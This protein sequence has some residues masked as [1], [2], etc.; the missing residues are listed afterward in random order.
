VTT[1]TK[2]VTSREAVVGQ[3]GF[4]WLADM[5]DRRKM[6][7]VELTIVILAI[8]AQSLLA[9]RSYRTSRVF[10]TVLT[11]WKHFCRDSI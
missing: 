9:P 11:S 7:G 6:Y 3:L 10:S 4:G 8:L 2:A 1:A 5:I